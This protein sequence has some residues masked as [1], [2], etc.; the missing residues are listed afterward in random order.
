MAPTALPDYYAEAL[1]IGKQSRAGALGL[2]IYDYLLTLDL[3]VDVLWRQRKRSRLCWLY[4]FNRLFP[5]IWLVLDL[6]LPVIS[7]DTGCYYS[8]IFSISAFFWLPALLYEPLL[9]IL[10][11]WKAWGEDRLDRFRRDRR[12]SSRQSHH[13]TIDSGRLVKAFAQDSVVYFIGVFI[14]LAL[15]TIVW[16]HYNGYINMVVPWSGALPSIL[17]SRLFL[18]MR[19]AML[20]PQRYGDLLGASTLGR[21][22]VPSTV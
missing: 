1:A 12:E 22:S 4:F 9:C 10:V 21:I 20:F 5:L 16:S 7:T 18:H 17:G 8:G 13:L 6:E 19:E 3:E 14:Q 15:S 11:V 2:L